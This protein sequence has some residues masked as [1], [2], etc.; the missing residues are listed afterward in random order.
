ML[1]RCIIGALAAVAVP[2]AFADDGPH[3]KLT[4]G[5]YVYDE[6]SGND[7]NLRWRNSTS[8][9][10]LGV[11][12]D[13][14]FGS[15][16][17]A[18]ADTT[19]QPNRFVQVQPS[20]QA[21]TGGFFGGSLNVQV[22]DAWYVLAGLGRTNLRPYFNLNFDPNDAVTWGVGHRT[23]GGANLSVFVVADNRLGTGQQDWHANLRLPVQDCRLT[24][25]VQYKRGEGDVG[26]VRAWGYSAAWDFPRWFLRVTRDPYQNFS[27]QDAW[28]FA[29]G[30][31]F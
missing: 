3:W 6:A 19:F 17:R 13:A 12:D 29:G 8:S 24:L 9:L 10:W 27:A 23:S 14:Q 7:L 15:Q 21:A 1:L 18:G 30:V 26:Y 20:L 31:R 28:R 11:Y 25:D 4:A 16:W 5:R 22:G 2:A